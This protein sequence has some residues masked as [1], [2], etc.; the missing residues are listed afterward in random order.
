MRFDKNRWK[1]HGTVSVHSYRR[2]PLDFKDP[3]RP[4]RSFIFE[5]RTARFGAD[6]TFL[7]RAVRCGAVRC[8]AVRCG[9]VRCGL[10]FLIILRLVCAPNHTSYPTITKKPH[11]EKPWYSLDAV[12]VP[13]TYYAAV[14]ILHFTYGIIL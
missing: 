7:N 3:Q 8:G 13:G 12:L 1:A 14:R 5:I 9:E 6:F 4:N 2:K 10:Y 11:R